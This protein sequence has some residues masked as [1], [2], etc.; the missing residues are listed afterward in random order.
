MPTVRETTPEACME[1]TNP[2][3]AETGRSTVINSDGVV[4]DRCYNDN[5]YSTCV[6][7]SRASQD[8]DSDDLCVNCAESNSDDEV[9]YR[10]INMDNADTYRSQEHGEIIKSSRR[11]GIELETQ[12]EYEEDGKKASHALPDDVGVS[13]DGSIRGFGLE[14]QTP[15]ASGKLAETLI[16]EVCA[17]VSKCNATV[18]DSCGYHVHIDYADVDSL[19][20]DRQFNRIRQLWLF[21][22]AFEDVLISFLPESRRKKSRY[23]EPL[24]SE[25]HF[26]EVSSTGNMDQ[27]EKL[28]YRTRTAIDTTR[29]KSDKKHQTRYRGINMHTLLTGRHLEIRFHSGTI[30]PRKVL[31]WANLHA[32][33]GD[34]ILGNLFDVD[35]LKFNNNSIDLKHKTN[36]F[37]ELVCLDPKSEAYFRARQDK[38][39]PK[40]EENS[41]ALTETEKSSI[42]E[43]LSANE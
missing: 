21:Y 11:F 36:T 12:Y 43:V 42:V 13:T 9:A 18:D 17:T 16:K 7:C 31:E 39:T 4:C 30:N 34:R 2:I 5:G 20:A 3:T 27:L 40:T 14:V 38:F 19:S 29:C 37:F 25:Y 1:C 6:E 32:I 33:I 35:L 28:W 24:R 22:I 41:P 26:K 8:I 10:D 15:P 23:C